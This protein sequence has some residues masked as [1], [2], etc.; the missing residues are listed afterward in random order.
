MTT[1]PT[2]RASQLQTMNRYLT[3]LTGSSL[4]AV[5]LGFRQLD[6]PPNVV[7]GS[8]SSKRVNFATAQAAAMAS[9]VHVGFGASTSSIIQR[10]GVEGAQDWFDLSRAA[11]AR[12]AALGGLSEVEPPQHHRH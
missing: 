3:T 8:C 5:L 1:Q 4:V 6:G 7:G 11:V 2:Q 9:M 10:F 12:I